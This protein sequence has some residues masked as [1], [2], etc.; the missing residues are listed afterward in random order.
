MAN[1]CGKGGGWGS[2]MCWIQF[3][4]KTGRKPWYEDAP[5]AS[6]MLFNLG[7][8]SRWMIEVNVRSA[9]ALIS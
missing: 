2:V 3:R 1:G 5:V 9:A 8:R 6:M 7:F 4:T